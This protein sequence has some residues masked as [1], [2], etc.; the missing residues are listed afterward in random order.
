[1]TLQEQWNFSLSC[2][3]V[4]ALECRPV[5]VSSADWSLP[6]VGG[7][8][9]GSHRPVG[10]DLSLRQSSRPLECGRG[11]LVGDGLAE[12]RLCM[13]V[14]AILAGLRGAVQAEI[15]HAHGLLAWQA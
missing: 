5:C 9:V 3:A 4:T 14:D 1:M 8:W 11:M 12:W 2:S 15:L 7:R 13:S 10:G 6:V